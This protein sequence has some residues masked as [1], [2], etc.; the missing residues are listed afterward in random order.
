MTGMKKTTSLILVLLFSAVMLF[1]EA[2]NT[3]A[4]AALCCNDVLTCCGAECCSGP[5]SPSF[6]HLDC[7]DGSAVTCRNKQGTC[8]EGDGVVPTD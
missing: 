7:Q 4:D 5:G 2:I 8:G 6:C 1:G 3:S